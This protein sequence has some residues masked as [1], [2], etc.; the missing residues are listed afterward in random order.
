MDT[1]TL[2]GRLAQSTEPVRPLPRPWVRTAMWIGIAGLYVA[3]VVLMM[4]PRSDLPAKLA[5]PRYLIEQI[6]ALATGIAAATAAFASVIPGFD[7]KILFVPAI[8]FAV[9]L[10]SLG[11]GCIQN[12]LRF[13]PD[14]LSLQPD[15]I[16]LPAIA[17]VGAGPAIV[18]AIM[19]RRGAPLRPHMTVFLG[20]LAA[21]GVG[22]FGLRLF[23]PQDAS[24]M[25]LVWQF[26]SVLVLSA[27]AGLC[28]KYLL[29]WPSLIKRVR[30][31]ASLG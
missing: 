26:G 28:G 27:L 12:L 22:N 24:L 5:D 18:A 2:I 23:H 14:G 15:W 17:V 1:G 9:W 29:N 10:G 20:G 7:R 16:C 3:F 11:E 4:S 25:V 6:A 30:Q 21:A 8:P 31:R 13:G 19:I